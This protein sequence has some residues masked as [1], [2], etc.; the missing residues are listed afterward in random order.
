MVLLCTKKAGKPG[1]LFRQCGIDLYGKLF[2]KMLG[3][4]LE[5]LAAFL[6]VLVKSSR[7]HIN[8]LAK[9]Q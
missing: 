6:K 7:V 2:L 3:W 8:D 5:W 9:L 4:Y 1:E